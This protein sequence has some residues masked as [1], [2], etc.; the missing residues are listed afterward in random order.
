MLVPEQS[1]LVPVA[2]AQVGTPATIGAWDPVNDWD[3]FGKH[4]A[5]MHNGKVL[6]WPTGEDAFVWDPVTNVKTAVP[7]LFGDLHCAAQTTLADG[8]V[9]VAGGVGLSTHDGI[10]VTAIF[11]PNT[12]QWSMETPM[13][14][15][16]W[17][18]TTTTLPDGRVLASSGDMPGGGYAD[19]PEIYDPATDTWTVLPAASSKDI[20]LY[21]FMF[22]LPNGKVYN[23]GTKDKTFILDTTTGVWT[24]GPTNAFGSSGYAESG[25]MYA[26]GKVIRTGGGDPSFANAATIDMTAANP[27]W[28]QISPMNIP[29][30]RHN[31]VILADGDVMAVGGTRT[32]DDLSGAAYEGEIWNPTTGQWTVTAPMTYDRMYHSAALLL[33][34][35]SVLTS[36]GEND[37]RKN[38]QIFKPP[39]FFK[40]PRPVITAAASVAPYG[41]TFNVTTNRAVSSVALIRPAA[42]T[43]AFDQNQRYVPLT[44]SSTSGNTLTVNA[45]ASGGVAPPGYYMLIVKDSDGLPSVASWV[46]VDSAGNL[47]PG[48]ITGTIRDGGGNPIAGATVAYD[49]GSTTTNGSGQYTIA[50]IMPGQQ[51]ITASKGSEFASVSKIVLVVGNQTSTLDFTL[52]PPGSVTGTVTSSESGDPIAGATILHDSGASVTTDAN[53][54]FALIDIPSGDQNLS[55][56][57]FGYISSSAQTIA[58]PANDEVV[59]NIILTPKPTYIA[60]EVKDKVTKEPLAGATITDGTS[61]TTTD[62]FGRYQLFAPPG[63]YTL[64]ATIDGYTPRIHP[65]VLVTFGTYTAVD[66]E[67]DPINA[68]IT[69]EPV[70]DAF[71]RQGNPSDNFGDNELLIVRSPTTN[72]RN[73]Y[74][75]FNVT[76][77]TRPMQSAKLRLY[78]SKSHAQG[79]GRIYKVD[80]TWAEDQINF[81]NAPQFIALPLLGNI[82]SAPVGTWVEFD[83]SSTITGNGVVSFAL[84]SPTPLGSFEVNY[85]S[86]ENADGNAPQLVIQQDPPPSISGFTPS[87][88]LVGTQVTISGDNFVNIT[89]V[90]F[91]NVA[92]SSF[93]VDSTTKIRA[94]VPSSATSGKIRV[95]SGSD[96]A[97]SADDFTVIPPPPPAISG[98]TPANGPVGTLVTING[99]NFNGTTSV[100]FNGVA[101][102]S[103][104]IKSATQIQA[105]VPSSATSGKVSVTNAGGTTTSASSFMVTVAAPPPTISSFTPLSGPVGT[106]VTING[107]NFVGVTGLKFNGVAASS[108]TIESATRIRAQVPTGATS[109]KI[110]LTTVTGAASSSLSFTVTPAPQQIRSVYLPLINGGGSGGP[111]VAGQ[112]TAFST[113]ESDTTNFF[114]TLDKR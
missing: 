40:G 60:G 66:L 51:H 29:R 2:S 95:I 108:F 48:S 35:G 85:S 77:L 86:K 102:T 44:V 47:S 106:E 42:V 9:L 97:T 10:T 70:A 89:G 74:L 72:T 43:H 34:D 88:G 105:T 37:G 23:A 26:P 22:V 30:R 33:P 16:R 90:T 4:M 5:L 6:A 81:S 103:F 50:N 107:T 59:V 52:T 64:T 45:P 114:C 58:V 111:A 73:S 100:R 87:S 101:A 25:A 91:N 65:D 49:G 71:V 19:R 56:S 39:Y 63:T 12:S 1:A 80:N 11:D 68:P 99:S 112:F 15:P 96:T 55:A 98:F 110:S 3:I 28:T 69:V 79:G 67:L 109:G 46:R 57:A 75:R 61:I 93:T 38:A 17:Y 41:G 78:V 62:S 8:R 24:A 113:S 94:T 21:P 36:G 82:S 18:G 76:G 27:A 7:A 53:G 54:H 104:S 31:M 13:H 20:G 83:V 84:A 32:G 92:A 14:Y